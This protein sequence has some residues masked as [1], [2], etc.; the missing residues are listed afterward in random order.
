MRMLLPRVGPGCRRGPRSWAVRVCVRRFVS[1]ARA[2]GHSLVCVGPAW[3]N[4]AGGCMCPGQHGP[5]MLAPPR[6]GSAS[7]DP[8]TNIAELVSH[9]GEQSA[10]DIQRGRG[11]V[12]GS[13][14]LFTDIA[15]RVIHADTEACKNPQDLRAE[16]R[17]TKIGGT[18]TGGGPGTGQDTR[19]RHRRRS[20][21]AEDRA[22]GA[23]CYTWRRYLRRTGDV[24]GGP[25]P[26]DIKG[27]RGRSHEPAAERPEL[28]L[29]EPESAHCRTGTSCQATS[30]ACSDWSGERDVGPSVNWGY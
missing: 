6:H 12:H 4:P 29:G 18:G 5:G 11:F 9:P 21:P 7:H 2:M 1:R 15:A 8:S 13:D 3:R 23:T 27:G 26:A 28:G 10:V 14:S 19:L 17:A 22:G 30:L 20:R 24:G 16:G 25:G